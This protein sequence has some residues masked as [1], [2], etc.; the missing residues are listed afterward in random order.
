[1]K[2]EQHAIVPNDHWQI[3][4]LAEQ[5]QLYHGITHVYRTALLLV[6]LPF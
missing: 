4:Q 3:Y 6:V 2:G 1:M 5:Q